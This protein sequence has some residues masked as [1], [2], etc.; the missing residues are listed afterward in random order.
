M[1]TVQNKDHVNLVE[2]IEALKQDGFHVVIYLTSIRNEQVDILT[3]QFEI[4]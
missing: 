4:V 3:K 2:V 1:M